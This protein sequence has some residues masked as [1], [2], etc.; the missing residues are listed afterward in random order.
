MVKVKT[1]Q[2]RVEIKKKS[3][4]LFFI[5]ALLACNPT[6][7]QDLKIGQGGKCACIN[8]AKRKIAEHPENES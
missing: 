7:A 5:L 1:K 3:N 2:Q 4:S 8:V 6:N